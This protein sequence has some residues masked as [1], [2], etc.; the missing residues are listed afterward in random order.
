M[1]SFFTTLINEVVQ[2]NLGRRIQQRWDRARHEPALILCFY[3]TLLSGSICFLALSYSMVIDYM[4]NWRKSTVEHTTAEIEPRETTRN[5]AILAPVLASIPKEFRLKSKCDPL[6]QPQH[7][8]CDEISI[9]RNTYKRV[10]KIALSSAPPAK[11]SKETV[12]YQLE[13]LAESHQFSAKSSK[14]WSERAAN[15]LAEKKLDTLP[16][17]ISPAMNVNAIPS[18]C[19]WTKERDVMV[20]FPAHIA[21]KD[22]SQPVTP[23]KDFRIA[24]W[25]PNNKVDSTFFTQHQALV[26][27]AAVALE[28]TAGLMKES[29]LRHSNQFS[30][31]YVISA[32]GT[33]AFLSN[34][35]KY[36]KFPPKRIWSSATYFHAAWAGQS[37]TTSPYLDLA[38]KGIVETQ[39]D[40]IR[41]EPEQS[42]FIGV[43]C[44]DIALSSKEIDQVG[45]N[46]AKSLLFSVKELS[47][48][49]NKEIRDINFISGSSLRADALSETSDIEIRSAFEAKFAENFEDAITTV[50]QLPGITEPT[51]AVPIKKD[52]DD[53]VR[54]WLIRMRAPIPSWT[55]LAILATGIVLL[56]LSRLTLSYGRRTDK[57]SQAEKLWRTQLR[58]LPT[59]VIEADSD[60]RVLWGNERAEEIL[61]F[62]LRSR[63]RLGAP[64]DRSVIATRSASGESL[65]PLLCDLF[66]RS[67][68]NALG[69]SRYC[70]I[71]A[72]EIMEQRQ[73]GTLSRYF[74]RR[75]LCPVGTSNALYLWVEVRATPLI[76]GAPTKIGH[77][78]YSF[79]SFA[80]V[81]KNIADDLDKVQKQRDILGEKR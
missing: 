63:S 48:S 72:E 75:A 53:N 30:Q 15:Q 66:V 32:E 11:S 45:D 78:S 33:L 44:T 47:V 57:V 51:F 36:P 39:C 7:E 68:N 12:Q 54:F 79:A 22:P 17:D 2:T 71:S 76:S 62:T 74:A 4:E 29:G 38:G 70:P 14:E 61:Q 56:M 18:R 37:H 16:C 46:L 28:L 64:I 26:Y 73:G 55:E 50:W 77:A 34:E 65:N 24:V 42:R 59:G 35:R 80:P 43:V 23:Q 21:I 40:Q 25:G 1:S 19:M 8:V 60:G 52:L 49:A 58:S 31:A 6:A 67:E 20:H 9:F 41:N 81:D 5:L 13:K 3:S 10:L 69:P 27:K